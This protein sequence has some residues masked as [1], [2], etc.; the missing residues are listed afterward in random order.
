MIQLNFLVEHMGNSQLAFALTSTLND[1]A[2]TRSDLD[3]IVYY[4]TMHRIYMTPK[5]AM[6]QMVEAWGQPGYTIATSVATARKMLSFPG[7]QKRL[8]Y[9]WDLEWIRGEQIYYDMFAPLYQDPSI[10]LIAR[11]KIHADAINNCF[12]TGVVKP[13]HKDIHIVDDFN[14]EQLLEVIQNERINPRCCAA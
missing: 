14:E 13:C 2:D 9:V 3:A 4:N 7:T 11:S 1:L 8:F 5:F 6:M 12:N 10:V